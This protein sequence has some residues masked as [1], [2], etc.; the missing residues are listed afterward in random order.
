MLNRELLLASSSSRTILTFTIKCGTYTYYSTTGGENPS[1]RQTDY[2]GYVPSWCGSIVYSSVPGVIATCHQHTNSYG[3]GGDDSYFYFTLVLAS[4]PPG[5]TQG[6]QVI[7]QRMDNQK[8][9]LMRLYVQDSAWTM[10]ENFISPSDINKEV[11]FKIFY[12]N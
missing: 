9:I 4:I 3:S 12:P 8:S 1:K 5:Y 6:D 10:Y 11:T 7:V 2:I